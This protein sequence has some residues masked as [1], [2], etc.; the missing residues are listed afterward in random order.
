[1]LITILL[2]VSLLI[3][4]WYNCFWGGIPLTYQEKHNEVKTSQRTKS[5]LLFQLIYRPIVLE[6]TLNNLQH[7]YANN[8]AINTRE[9]V[10][11]SL[12]LLHI[13]LCAERNQ[14]CL[15]AIKTKYLFKSLKLWNCCPC[16]K[17]CI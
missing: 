4:Y 15:S 9:N 12:C 7:N 10:F 8:K 11:I 5:M 2:T 1:M 17:I 6:H 16:R 13:G 14:N 3:I